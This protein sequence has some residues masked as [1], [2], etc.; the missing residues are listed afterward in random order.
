[1]PSEASAAEEGGRVSERSE[2]AHV[3]AARGRGRGA[4]G[5]GSW[6]RRFFAYFLWANKESAWGP[7]GKAPIPGGKNLGR[8]LRRADARFRRAFQFQV[9]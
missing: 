9:Q 8:E 2:F 6:G 7:G 5:H 3:P 1:M 4:E